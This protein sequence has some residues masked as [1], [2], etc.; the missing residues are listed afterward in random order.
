VK[1]CESGL[2]SPRPRRAAET[3]NSLS[4]GTRDA[5]ANTWF[6]PSFAGTPRI[7]T[8]RL[9]VTISSNHRFRPTVA[10]K[11]IYRRSFAFP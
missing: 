11:D 10:I 2:T 7:V 3:E 8:F 4:V 1:L 5:L 9:L 6:D